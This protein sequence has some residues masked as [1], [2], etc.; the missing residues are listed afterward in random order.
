MEAHVRALLEQIEAALVN[1]VRVGGVSIHE[2]REIDCQSSKM[3]RPAARTLDTEG[4]WKDVRPEVLDR[5]AQYL[6][7]FDAKE[8]RYYLPAFMTWYLKSDG[9]IGG[10]E[11]VINLTPLDGISRR[12]DDRFGL[13]G[14]QQSLAVLAFLQHVMVSGECNAE[15][16]QNACAKYWGTLAKGA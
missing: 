10:E 9:R 7:F 5:N 8:M 14:D 16:A 12:F 4:N 13:L 3:K 1:V 6:A 11:L 15:D 2:A